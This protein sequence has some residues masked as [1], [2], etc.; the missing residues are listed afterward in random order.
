MTTSTPPDDA[1]VIVPTETVPAPM[2][3]FTGDQMRQ[4]FM[5][6]KNL[7]R[8]LDESMPDQILEIEGRPFRKKGYWRAIAVAFN[9][10]VEPVEE[11]REVQGTFE[12]GQGNFGYCVTYRARTTSGRSASG[13]GSCFAVEKAPRAQQN[14]WQSLPK[15]ASEHN[16]RSHAHTRAFNRAVS[17]LVGFGEVS[18]EEID[19]DADGPGPVGAPP[20]D[21]ELRVRDVHTRSGTTEKGHPWSLYVVTFSDGRSG[22]TFNAAIAALAQRCQDTRTVVQALLREGKKPGH[23]VLEELSVV[24]ETV[25]TDPDQ[26]F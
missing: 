2:P 10:T 7:Q 17:N 22:S 11:R 21:G 13:D 23:L 19:R 24:K 20:E 6:Y 12:D 5:A 18:A 3:T 1:L 15:Q 25:P 16:V 4:A 8:C 26:P 14:R 9:L